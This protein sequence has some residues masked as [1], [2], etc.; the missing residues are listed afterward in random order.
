MWIA[1]VSNG[2]VITEDEIPVVPNE[3]TPW[4]Q[5]LARC[6]KEGLKITGLR[7]GVGPALANALPNKQCD[8]YWQ[9]YETIKFMISGAERLKQGIGSI[10]G[11]KVYITWME[12]GNNGLT[13]VWQEIRSLEEC[14]K[15]NTLAL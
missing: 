2:A 6:Q 8:G 9:G 12:L 11:D 10:V 7:L 5:L 15:G 13:Y 4:M 14:N 1:N 3:P